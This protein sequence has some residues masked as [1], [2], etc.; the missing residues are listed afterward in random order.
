MIKENN[1][2]TNTMDIPDTLE[3][4]KQINR[5][6]TVNGTLYVAPEIS[7]IV[8]TDEI[9]DYI[10]QYLM[11]DNNVDHAFFAAT[12]YFKSK[13][14]QKEVYQSFVRLIGQINIEQFFTDTEIYSPSF[15]KI[16]KGL[17]LYLTKT[18]NLSCIHCYNDADSQKYEELSFE[19]LKEVVDYFAPHV[20]NYSFSGGEPMVSPHFFPLAEYIKNTYP[21]K[22]LTLYSNGTLI[23]SIDIA[24]HI[25]E[26]FNEVQ[27]S[28]DGASAKTVDRV[29]GKDAFK[30]IIRGLKFL[31]NT[32]KK[33]EE[34]AVSICLFKFNI[35]D[36]SEHLL[37]LLDDIDP[38][39]KIK[40]IRFSNIEEEGRGKLEMQ[41]EK[42]DENIQ[43]IVLLQK[44][45]NF[46]G[47]R[48]WERYQEQV[49]RNYFC[50]NKGKKR[51]V[52]TT[53][54]FGQTLA[55]DSNG[56]IY[57]C[58]IK[59]GDINMGNFF[60]KEFRNNLF[61]TW[62]E[63]FY[64]HTVDKMDKCS[65]CDIKYYCCAGCRIKN[66]KTT[67]YYNIAP[68]DDAFKEKMLTKIAH[69]YSVN[70]SSS[71]R[72]ILHLESTL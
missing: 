21:D 68:C 11:E 23:N 5:Y 16:E 62:K 19:Q 42:T 8:L 71:N 33:I 35:D 13:Y 20:I 47:R 41:Y 53:C 28:L 56:D 60:D 17:H 27:I 69:D 51:R 37:D 29:R 32:D 72:E 38:E 48:I 64:N 36:L 65:D 3:L 61:A 25:S 22:S 15:E 18:C 52:S 9:S 49:L 31:A 54:S 14:S 70:Y 59:K 34:L 24:N 39:K 43:K 30:R 4:P 63:Y 44:K 2:K 7:S 46:S 26:L 12:E 45:I 55:L 58:A 40:S 66:K 1:V 67:G 10:M 57:P 6:E 50:F